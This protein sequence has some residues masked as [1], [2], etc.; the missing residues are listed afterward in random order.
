[1]GQLDRWPGH[2][3]AIL[4]ARDVV[5]GLFS[6][7]VVIFLGS[8]IPKNTPEDPLVTQQHHLLYSLK[9]SILQQLQTATGNGIRTAPPMLSFLKT[10]DTKVAGLSP[11]ER[12]PALLRNEELRRLKYMYGKWEPIQK[13]QGPT[14]EAEIPLEITEPIGTG[15]TVRRVDTDDVRWSQGAGYP[16][17]PAV[18]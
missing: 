5:Y 3:M 11:S 12:E 8:A 17:V 13:W 18:A 7:P 15:P 6:F 9:E 2:L 1:V 16:A 14:P 4:R 10:F